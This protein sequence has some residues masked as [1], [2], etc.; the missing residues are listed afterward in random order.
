MSM[1]NTEHSF[2]V[3]RKC[4]ECFF[5]QN[6]SY[7]LLCLSRIESNRIRISSFVSVSESFYWLTENKVGQ[8]E[9]ECQEIFITL[10]HEYV[11]PIGMEQEEAI[12]FV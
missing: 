2:I 12:S 6:V 8:N 9:R 5:G 3:R 10:A 7:S 4:D 11:I 1:G